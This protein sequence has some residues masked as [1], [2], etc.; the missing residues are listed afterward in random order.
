MLFKIGIQS[1]NSNYERNPIMTAIKIIS[2][3]YKRDVHFETI[4][5]TTNE[6]EHVNYQNNP[7]SQLITEDI[8]NC[9]FPFKAN[10]ILGL[11]QDEYGADEDT[12]E[13]VFEGT[14]DEFLE[15]DEAGDGIKNISLKRADI[16]LENARDILPKIVDIFSE[17]QPIVEE[18]ISSNQTREDIEH[19]IAK[20]LDASNDIVPI[21]VLGNYSS[22]KST[23][24][25]A[26]IGM[27][28]LPSGDMPVTA[29]IY[30]ISQMYEANN[31]EI[32]FEFDEKT[33]AIAIAEQ[34]YSVTC[35]FDSEL[36]KNLNEVL[37]NVKEES[38]E[39]KVN[40]CLEVINKQRSGV[41][42]LIN[43]KIPFATG[44]LTDAKNSFVI[45]DTPGSNTATYKEH[46]EI[47]QDAMK[48]LSNGIPV[49][50]AEYNSLDSC[51]NET[52]FS[53][54]KSI[55][56]I[57]S[58]FTMI[59][60]NKADAA[61]IKE[62]VFDKYMENMILEQAVPRNL[63]S[64][65]IYFVSSIMGLGSKKGGDFIDDHMDE[66]FEDNERKYSD[67]DSKRYKTLYMH[68]IMPEQ[69]KKRIV[70]ASEIAENKI[71]ANS[72]LMAIESEI[73]NFAEQYSAYDKCVQSNTYMD[74]IIQA[75]Q[76]EIEK[77]KAARQAN[78]NE[79]ENELEEDKKRL[80]SSMEMQ[81]NIL[82]RGYKDDYNES[83]NGCYNEARFS[84]THDQ[85]KAMELNIQAE[86][87]KE[88]NLSE[89]VED[90]KE[91]RDAILD[92]FHN[93]RT[94]GI[95]GFVKDMG[96]DIK[97]TIENTQELREAKTRMDEETA[98]ELLAYIT[99]DFNE[100]LNNSIKL[101]A[102]AS[103]KYWEDN[104]ERI[105]EEQL[106]LVAESD[107]LDE[108]KK[109]ELSEIITTYGTVKFK[110]DL[111]FE[112][113]EFERRIRLL[114][115]TIDLNKINTKKLTEEYNTKFNERIGTATATIREKHI[116]S[117][118]GW[119][120]RLVDKI[121]T[122]IVSYSPKLSKQAIEIEEETKKIE[123]LES[124]KGILQD[125]SN[126]VIELMD[127]RTLA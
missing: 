18:H 5:N 35:E 65:G 3:P 20:F 42:D 113:E 74:N 58:R 11:L 98:D 14:T 70:T 116:K 10:E 80:I 118:D 93:L 75:T 57:D 119:R 12:L 64:G 73:V 69:I 54:V 44:P 97:G 78:K 96:E 39:E 115:V 108:E 68:N 67:P 81:S 99:D 17:V 76:E 56:Q 86:N 37:Q 123:Q 6:W 117:F 41:S 84:Y 49:Y 43:I 127:W 120:N 102:A 104:A 126:Q 40:Q 103:R 82:T 61:N 105:K 21:C 111:E 27:E 63:Y 100:R 13:I 15:L 94:R 110:D 50:V 71:F 114:W 25:N 52:L 88:H 8:Q 101:I 36:V 122:N 48:N 22:G 29:K 87:R 33:I 9:F 125:Y 16:G 85:I 24:I 66:F 106:M 46:F 112:R 59:V 91:S 47:L 28:I 83:L 34:D 62:K 4:N 95:S 77:S 19:D 90:I 89:K 7:G 31:A 79:L 107:S 109:K 26:L 23:F 121:R 45:F 92:N 124:T 60:V 38:L 30:R 32:D 72:G 51:D 55:S 1:Y 53:K 2:D